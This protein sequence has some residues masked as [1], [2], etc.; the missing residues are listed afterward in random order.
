VYGEYALIVSVGFALIESSPRV[1]GIHLLVR[2]NTPQKYISHSLCVV[3]ESR[4]F[5][6]GDP[7]T[8]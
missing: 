1:R 5:L 4:I 7:Q 6:D 8:N 2:V 3:D